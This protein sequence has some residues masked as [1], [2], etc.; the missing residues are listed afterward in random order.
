M[1]LWLATVLLWTYGKPTQLAYVDCALHL[2]PLT[3][4]SVLLRAVLLAHTP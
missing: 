4:H 3:A 2:D 1:Q